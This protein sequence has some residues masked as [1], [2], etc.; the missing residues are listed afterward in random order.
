MKS[1]TF[2]GFLTK[3]LP[4]GSETLD[5]LVAETKRALDELANRLLGNATEDGGVWLIRV[6][7]KTPPGNPPRNAYYLWIDPADGKMRT[8]G[9]AGTET[10]IGSP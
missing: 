1:S 8:R 6:G 3:N 9:S 2:R 7:T 5:T 10:V 4:G